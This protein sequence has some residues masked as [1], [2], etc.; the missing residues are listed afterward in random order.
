MEKPLHC[1]R[2][3]SRA[4]EVVIYNR[5]VRALLKENESHPDY[6]DRW[7]DLMR[8][9]VEAADAEEAEAMAAR[10]YPPEAGFVIASVKA[11]SQ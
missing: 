9:T 10:R 2:P 5:Q 3:G 8:Q 6:D 1:P 7:A 4:Y 11:V